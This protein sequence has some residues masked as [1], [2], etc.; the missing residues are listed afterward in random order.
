MGR[1]TWGI[2]QRGASQGK[3]P[4]KEVILTNTL[5]RVPC[6]IDLRES[7]LGRVPKR[8]YPEEEV[9]DLN[10]LGRVPKEID[11]SKSVLGRVR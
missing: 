4:K 3:C 10:A 5:V 11:P 9:L 6:R 8:K 2:D 1:A 7:V